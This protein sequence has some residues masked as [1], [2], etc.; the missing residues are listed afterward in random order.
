MR[1]IIKIDGEKCNGC[2]LCVPSCA[3][4]AIQI[5]D[6]KARLISDKYCDGLGACLGEC[7]EGALEIIE[8]EAEQFDENAVEAHLAS[9]VA[10]GAV[11]SGIAAHSAAHRDGGTAGQNHMAQHVSQRG[12]SQQG[13]FQ[14]CPGSRVMQFERREEAASTEVTAPRESTLRQWPV[15][16]MLVP[17]NA[18]YFQDANLLIAADCVPFAHAGFHEDLLRGRVLLVG[19]PKLDDIDYYTEKLTNIFRSSNIKSVKVATMEVPCCS[20]LLLAIRRAIEASGKQIP[21]DS[22]VVGVRGELHS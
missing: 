11:S 20:G 13:A 9:S 17:V 22:V 10:V 8:R 12:G 16:L 6:G 19:C 18:P 14:G 2:G 5:V 15:Q 4:G 3:E 21:L 7:P 1:K